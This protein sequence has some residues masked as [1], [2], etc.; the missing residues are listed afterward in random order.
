MS[1]PTT[2]EHLRRIAQR[3]TARA[4]T[5]ACVEVGSGG[6]VTRSLTSEPGSSAFLAGSFILTADAALWPLSLRHDDSAHPERPGSIPRLEGLAADAR[7]AFGADWALAVE[8]LP[9]AQRVCAYALLRAPD[10]TSTLAIA[11]SAYETLQSDSDGMVWG[12]LAG[13]AR[14]LDE[15]GGVST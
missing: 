12:I 7:Q 9:A 6:H 4:E 13:L 14:R 2:K 5:L 8:C 1:G 3:L 10:G 15:Q 11:S